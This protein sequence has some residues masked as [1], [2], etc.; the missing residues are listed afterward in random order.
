VH[1]SVVTAEDHPLSSVR[2]DVFGVATAVPHVCRASFEVQC[3]YINLAKHFLNF[4]PPCN[5]VIALG[6]SLIYYDF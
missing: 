6:V 5:Y 4:Y 3:N 1:G 2:D